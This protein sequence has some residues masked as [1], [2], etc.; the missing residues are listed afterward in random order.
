MDCEQSRHVFSVLG[1]SSHFSVKGLGPL[2]VKLLRV[3]I[4]LTLPLT[5]K[6]VVLC[7][8]G[9]FTPWKMVLS[10][11]PLY[12]HPPTNPSPNYPQSS[13]GELDSQMT[14]STGPNKRVVLEQAIYLLTTF[15]AGWCWFLFC[16]LANT[17]GKLCK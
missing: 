7:R 9:L 8:N 4:V 16:S 17:G 15:Y 11:F 12:T 6:L 14:C 2:Q 13:N 1:H 10:G 3:T 5:W